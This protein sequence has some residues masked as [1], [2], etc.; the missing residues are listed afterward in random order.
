MSG[1]TE[2]TLRGQNRVTDPNYL[3]GATGTASPAAAGYS[4][5]EAVTGF[6]RYDAITVVASLQGATGGTIDVVVEHSPDGT[7]WYELVHLTQLAAA[8]T[9]L[10]DVW[11]PGA[12]G[13]VTVVGRNLTTTTALASGAS[14]GVRWFDQMRVRMVAGVSTSAGAVQIVNVYGQLNGK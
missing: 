7:D 2:E 5:S 1:A 11:S 12:G 10:T 14:S 9:A 6:A 8:A 4:R 3:L 13:T